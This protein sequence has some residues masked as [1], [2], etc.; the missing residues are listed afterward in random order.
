VSRPERVDDLAGFVEFAR[1]ARERAEELAARI[2]QEVVVSVP[3][4]LVAEGSDRIEPMLDA[5]GRFVFYPGC[6]RNTR[7]QV[8]VRR[9]VV[10][11]TGGVGLAP[12]VVRTLQSKALSIHYVVE[13]SGRVV[14]TAGHGTRCA[15]AGIANDES[16]GIEVVSRGL[17]TRRDDPAT[18]WRMGSRKL[19]VLDWPEAQHHAAV[20]LVEALCGELGIPRRIP[21]RAGEVSHERRPGP[22]GWVRLEG[23]I[24]HYHAHATKLDPGGPFFEA[25][26]RE[27][28]T[29]TW[30]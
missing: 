4:V 15:H 17:A 7:A 21:G 16:I 12:R 8:R 27:G 28:L 14:Q 9:V 3:P 26:A 23:V 25:L 11:W 5:Q 13:P 22:D 24:G 18:E 2:A 30:A 29:P 10:H 6:S 19:R 1:R 20:W